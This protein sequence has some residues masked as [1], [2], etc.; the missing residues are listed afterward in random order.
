MKCNKRY[1]DPYC[2]AFD[3]LNPVA[4]VHVLIIPKRHTKSIAHVFGGGQEEEKEAALTPQECDISD[5]ALVGKLLAAAA[6][7]A[8][9]IGIEREGY[10]LVVN[11]GAAAGQSV[12]HLHVHLLGGR[13]FSWP[14]G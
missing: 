2:L 13:Q 3:D 12:P 8:S 5:E 7:V 1:E 10:R 11:T 6:K 14:P 9:D 4:P